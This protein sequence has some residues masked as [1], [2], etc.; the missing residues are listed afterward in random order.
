MVVEMNLQ[1]M[2]KDKF[3]RENSFYH[4]HC[5][6][7]TKYSSFIRRITQSVFTTKFTD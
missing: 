6:L 4:R 5:E 3:A 2:D 7:M 1:S